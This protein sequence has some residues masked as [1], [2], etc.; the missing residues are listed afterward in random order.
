VERLS[1]LFV[2]LHD[3]PELSGQL[4]SRAGTWIRTGHTLEH[5]AQLYTAAMALTVARRR[6]TDG[7]WIDG[8]SYAVNE[9]GAGDPDSELF[10]RWADVRRRAT[11]AR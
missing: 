10:R 5:A 2:R 7:A 1:E 8:V 6:A 11:A 9:S 3:D 4:R